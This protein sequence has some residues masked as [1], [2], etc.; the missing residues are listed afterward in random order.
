M[1]HFDIDEDDNNDNNNST[2]M[3]EMGEFGPVV[4]E[5]VHPQHLDVISVDLT[6]DQ[7][8][9]EDE[10]SIHQTTPHQSSS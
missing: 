3:F 7:E 1:N 6:L 8:L 10:R 4:I 9:S 2:M 5:N